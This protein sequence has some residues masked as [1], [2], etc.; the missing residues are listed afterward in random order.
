[1]YQGYKRLE[2]LLGLGVRPEGSRKNCSEGSNPIND[3]YIAPTIWVIIS[4]I[5]AASAI[6]PRN[7]SSRGAQSYDCKTRAWAAS[8][9]TRTGLEPPPGLAVGVGYRSVGGTKSVPTRRLWSEAVL[10]TWWTTQEPTW[11]WSESWERVSTGR[12]YHI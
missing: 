3:S 12:A 11:V 5:G 9:H 4:P 7:R 10:G 1:M 8:R 6:I 2:H